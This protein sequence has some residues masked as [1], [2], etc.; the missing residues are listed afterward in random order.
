MKLYLKGDFD[1]DRNQKRNGS[2]VLVRAVYSKKDGSFRLELCYR[3]ETCIQ[4]VILKIDP[5]GGEED[6]V[7][8]N[9]DMVNGLK[10]PLVTIQSITDSWYMFAN[11]ILVATC[12]S[13]SQEK[14]CYVYGD[15]ESAMDRIEKKLIEYLNKI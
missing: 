14:L 15:I 5:L 11:A 10:A 13:I 1:D 12:S 2:C 4:Y 8:I 7:L 6:V 9:I 3:N